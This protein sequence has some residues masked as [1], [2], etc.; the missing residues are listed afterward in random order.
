MGTVTRISLAALLLLVS[1]A[2][3]FADIIVLKSGEEIEGVVVR[4]TK[5]TV[6]YTDKDDKKQKVRARDVAEI[7]KQETPWQEFDRRL[8]ELAD[9]DSAGRLELATFG[10][11]HDLEERAAEVLEAIFKIDP[12]NEEARA[13]GGFVKDDKGKWITEKELEERKM[14]EKAAKMPNLKSGNNDMTIAGEKVVIVPPKG[15]NKM[16][17]YPCVFVFHGNGD[18]AANFLSWFV[19]KP[20]P[21]YLVV[22]FE[23]HQGNGS[24]M[25]AVLPVLD[26]YI[27]YDKTRLY[28]LGMSGGA[29][30]AAFA[31]FWHKNTFAAVAFGAGGMN[32]GYDMHP[33]I[34]DAPE[35]PHGSYIWAGHG[36]PN[37]FKIA[38]GNMKALKDR[39]YPVEWKPFSGGHTDKAPNMMKEI[40][41]YF[42]RHQ[43]KQ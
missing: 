17:S 35:N 22:A 18:T 28:A 6:F 29:G 15:Y 30:T 9:D 11:E 4:E 26:E 20:D 34:P 23:Q 33:M 7:K 39:G 37:H 25:K 27:N 16:K 12:D 3:V 24:Q 31:P 5:S 8:G 2:V 38:E 40:W 10:R 42:G 19:G 13:A 32:S 41:A 1:S 43:L 36:D 21:N 14:R